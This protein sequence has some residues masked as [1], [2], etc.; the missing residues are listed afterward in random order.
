NYFG[1]PSRGTVVQLAEHPRGVAVLW[2]E[3]RTWAFRTSLLKDVT[4]KT[5]F[6]PGEKSQVARGRVA[7]ERV[8]A[9]QH[10]LCGCGG[11]SKSGFVPGH[12]AKLSSRFRR[13]ILGKGTDEDRAIA[14]SERVRSHPKV[15]G[16]GY[17]RA[18][19]KQATS[20]VSDEAREAPP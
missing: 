2:R 6:A 14:L 8:V 11:A 9:T 7:A 15:Q 10:C 18:L 17:L 4:A 3:F 1:T 13:L 12:D 16:S 19:L 20:E 5:K